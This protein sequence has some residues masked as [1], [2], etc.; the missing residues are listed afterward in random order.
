[1]PVAVL[2]ERMIASGD[3]RARAYGTASLEARRR[4]VVRINR[5]GAEVLRAHAR[6][7]AV[8]RGVLEEL[9]RRTTPVTTE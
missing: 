8:G 7:T 5:E 3:A 6:P 4:E 2:Y 9:L 1:V